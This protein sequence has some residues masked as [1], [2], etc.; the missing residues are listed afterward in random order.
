MSDQHKAR[1]P[2]RPASPDPS[3]VPDPETD[4]AKAHPLKPGQEKVGGEGSEDHS[5]EPPMPSGHYSAT[6]PAAGP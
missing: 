2:E 5:E 3:K 4:P 1:G 6:R